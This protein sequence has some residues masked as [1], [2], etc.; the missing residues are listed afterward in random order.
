DWNPDPQPPSTSHGQRTTHHG[1]I[2][3]MSWQQ[4][5]FILKGVYLGLLVFV[6]IQLPPANWWQEVGLVAL[7]TLGGLALF[8][9]VAAIRKLREGYRVK[10]RLPA[11]ILFLLLENPALVYAGIILGLTAGA[12]L[13]RKTTDP[14]HWELLATV[15]GGAVLGYL[16]WMLI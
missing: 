5:E 9:G 10:G 12:I 13:V 1:Q 4:T 16:F 15:G 2:Q 11:F 8:L 6:G 14:E 7:C 3:P